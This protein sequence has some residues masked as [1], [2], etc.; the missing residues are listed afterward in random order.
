MPGASIAFDQVRPS[1]TSYGSP[2]RARNDLWA[3]RAI[4][5]R[6]TLAN[7]TLH[8]WTLLDAPAGSGA[9]LANALTPTATF[10]PDVPGSYR[11]RLVTNGGGPGN[12]QILIAAVRY[13]STGVLVQRGWRLPALGEGPGENNF[14]G[15][16]RSWSEAFDFVFSDLLALAEQIATPPPP[17]P[18]PVPV[19]PL[20]VEVALVAGLQ[21][22]GTNAPRLIAATY[23]DFQNQFPAT[24]NG[25]TR[26]V[27]LH[28]IIATSNPA[29]AAVAQLQDAT[30]AVPPAIWA[31]ATTTA[32]GSEEK[33]IA[34]V[35]PPGMAGIP[36]APCR[37]EVTLKSNGT[38][39]LQDRAFCFSAKLVVSYQ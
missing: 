6:S 9:S 11:I 3:G 29:Q 17:P 12:V 32:A 39:A 7:N 10:T 37:L 19:A 38:D 21:D 26:H 28:V 20:P 30:S 24:R 1:G 27:D 4:T 36:N 14:G 16:L 35:G 25:F 5:C 18:P 31:T 15:Q 13:D 33:V 23:V 22:A 2:D 8:E 34:I